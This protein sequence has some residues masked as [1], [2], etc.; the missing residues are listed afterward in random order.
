MLRTTTLA[1]KQ[2][3]WYIFFITASVRERGYN[4]GSVS[5]EVPAF[6]RSFRDKFDK[7]YGRIINKEG[8]GCF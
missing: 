3:L 8:G 2:E 5:Y 6:R 4:S 7:N 1:N